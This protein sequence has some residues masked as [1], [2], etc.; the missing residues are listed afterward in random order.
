M[1]TVVLRLLCWPLFIGTIVA[2][3]VGAI[4]GEKG[5]WRTWRN[6]CLRARL[7]AD[8][9]F[10]KKF[11]TRW[12]GTTLGYGMF[13]A[14]DADQKVE[15]HEDVHIEQFED[16]TIGGFWIGA[17]A[18]AIVHSWWGFGAWLACWMLTVWAVYFAGTLVAWLRSEPDAY[19]G[20]AWEEAAYAITQVKCESMGKK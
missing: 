5:A 4:W 6:G 13:L 8:S 20:N 16:A 2:S 12:G 15:D 7:R 18:C 14:P 9:W 17:I 3:I 11:Y 1:K 19:R 10:Y